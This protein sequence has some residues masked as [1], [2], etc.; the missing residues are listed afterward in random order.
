MIAFVRRKFALVLLTQILAGAPVLGAFGAEPKA[1]VAPTP[2]ARPAALAAAQ[3]PTAPSDKSAAPAISDAAVLDAAKLGL[4]QIATAIGNPSLDDAELA[5]E[6]AAI[7][8]IS[9]KIQDVLAKAAPRQAAIK[10]RLDQLGPAPD[11]KANPPAAPEDPAVA[12]DRADQTKI[13]T[14]IDD[15]SKRANLL[16][17]RA[18]QIAS[19]IGDRR[20]ALF[21]QEVFQS[22][23]SI[24]SPSL[25]LVVAHETPR[26]LANAQSAFSDFF[27]RAADIGAEGSAMTFGALALLLALALVAASI[28]AW[29]VIPREKGRREPNELR[30]VAAALWTAMAVATIPVV[31]VGAL[32]QLCDWFGVSDAQLHPLSVALF[33][34][35]VRCAVAAGLGSAILA[36]GRPF[37][38]PVEL[39]DRVAQRVMALVLAIAVLVTC[40]KLIEGM[41]E[42]VGASLQ[43]SVAARGLFAMLVGVT[44][45]RALYGIMGSHD[46]AGAVQIED[47]SPWWPPIRFAAWA[48]TFVA[49]PR[50]SA[51]AMSRLPRSS[52]TRSSGR[53]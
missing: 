1:T 38:R 25:W 26:A 20:R 40:G 46:G 31:G 50:R 14:A 37:W 24:L 6:A 7:A 3:G 16:E 53:R 17:L 15:V 22:S 2:P 4:D 34:G 28:V 36:P 32:F 21:A 51:A 44:L 5:R 27:L 35:V 11:P 9:A 42:A 13:F 39:T 45:G 19:A 48:A 49:D 33:R 47:E 43:A 8:P 30:R 18:E 12:R 41:N 52:S 23:S 29:R 10:A